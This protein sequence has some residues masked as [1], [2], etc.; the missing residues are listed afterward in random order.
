MLEQQRVRAEEE[1]R[2]REIRLAVADFSAPGAEAPGVRRLAELNAEFPGGDPAWL[3]KQ[4]NEDGNRGEP[5]THA[6]VTRVIGLLWPPAGYKSWDR[7]AHGPYPGYVGSLRDT[8]FFLKVGSKDDR[9]GRPPEQISCL[10]CSAEWPTGWPGSEA[11]VNGKSRPVCPD[12][13]GLS[14][15]WTAPTRAHSII[16]LHRPSTRSHLHPSRPASSRWRR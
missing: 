10:R 4:L 9:I 11:V 8:P 16:D 14:I 5:W 13:G 15:R 1:A 2:L 6:D 3:A 7:D 12:C